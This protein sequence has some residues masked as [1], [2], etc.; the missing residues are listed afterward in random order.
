MTILYVE[1]DLDDC[2]I[3]KEAVQ[4]V[5]PKT[6]CLVV[7]NCNQ[8]ILYMNEATIVPDFIFLDINMPH[9]DGKEFLRILKNTRFSSIP[10]IMYST[11]NRQEDI[12]ECKKL[13]AVDF[14][15]KPFTFDGVCDVIK[16][17]L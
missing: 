8:A 1:D 14:V 9:M 6:L 5:S 10:V 16:R 4:V 17:V 7:N 12:S 11:S 15:S 2:E 13:G 3:F